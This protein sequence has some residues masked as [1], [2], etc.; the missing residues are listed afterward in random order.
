APRRAREAADVVPRRR[1]PGFAERG[2]SRPRA[3][4]GR[5]TLAPSTSSMRS[6]SARRA[7]LRPALLLPVLAALPWSGRLA[8][9]H[10]PAL[11]LAH[12]SEIAGSLIALVLGAWVT[13][14]IRRQER[15]RRTH[16]EDLERMS[17]VDPLTGLG[18]R[19]AIERD[20]ELILN[21]SR[22]F[23]HPLALLH[24]DV[25]GLGSLNDRFG[26]ALGDATLRS[27]GAVLRSSA[28]LGTDQ[29]YRVG[30][31]EFVIASMADP[32]AADALARRIAWI[33]YE[34]SPKRSKVSVGV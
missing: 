7:L 23:N 11:R 18:N 21:R 10:W 27:M 25:D 26:E 4:E 14:L 24:L 30:G 12:A 1:D 33:F 15:L 29:V 22:R 6:P 32:A 31:D 20:L 16:L 8:E 34:R 2:P 17:L 5:M 3:R 13:A 9:R 28:R 19:R